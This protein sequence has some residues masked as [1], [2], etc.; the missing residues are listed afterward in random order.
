MKQKTN[1]VEF[2][3]ENCDVYDIPF[4]NI[5][6]FKINDLDYIDFINN[7]IYYINSY[8]LAIKEPLIIKDFWSKYIP[9]DSYYNYRDFTHITIYYNKKKFELSNAWIGDSE[10]A[11]LGQNAYKDKAGIYHLTFNRRYKPSYFDTLEMENN[12][13]YSIY[14]LPA[15]K[16]LL[17]I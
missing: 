17:M 10:Y 12:F 2:V 9:H 3:C 4:E 14:N 13:R 1:C 16:K 11:T 15:S 5:I 7:G 6:Y 8:D